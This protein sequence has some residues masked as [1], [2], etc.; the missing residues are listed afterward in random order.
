MGFRDDFMW[1]AATAA[2]QIEG[3]YNEDNKGLSVWDVFSHKEGSV[4]D[5]SNGDVACDHYHRYKEDIKLMADMGLKT[6]RLSLSWPRIIPTGTGKVN[7]KGLSF[8]D[9]VID[10]L[11][12]NNITPMVTLFH[13]DYPNELYKRGGILNRDSS[14]WFAEYTKVVV[15]RISD[16]VKYFITLNEPQCYVN[17]GHKNGTHAPG[18]LLDDSYI[19][20]G[21][22]NML[23][24]HGKSVQ[25]I[26]SYAKSDC[27]VGFAPVVQYSVPLT[28]SIEDIEAAKEHMFS[29]K[30]GDTWNAALWLDPVFKGQY[31]ND[32]DLIFKDKTPMIH[33]GDMETICQPIDFFGYNYY[34]S[35]IIKYDEKSGTPVM[36]QPEV[37][38]PHNSL[39]WKF[40]PRGMYYASKFFYE[41]YKKPII[42]TEN[43]MSN[44][45]FVAQDGK[46]YDPQRIEYMQ[47]HLHYLK[48][49]AEDGVDLL[50]YM[51]WSLMDNF[52]WGEGLN[53]RFGM[54]HV[55][56]QTLKRT[57][58]ESS[59][60]YENVI[61]TNGADL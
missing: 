27:Q 46:V 47:T 51:H 53:E 39:R 38:F 56:Y 42:I 23:L 60:W 35:D 25:A 15:E 58:K 50:G 49:T 1:G 2:Y 37:G 44:L 43:G 24:A 29:C 48:K 55:D 12:K 34:Q 13:W 41:R 22:H 6:Y 14:D 54:I 18:V 61:K 20:E 26:R 8:Y 28:D 4:K 36:C 17:L 11:L 21:I 30:Y 7:E 32:V 3:A 52:E 33:T 16:R 40:T 19:N 31:P 9:K 57:R 10:E 5:C 59:Y 45:D